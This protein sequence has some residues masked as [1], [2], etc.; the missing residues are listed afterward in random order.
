MLCKGRLISLEIELSRKGSSFLAFFEVQELHE[1][2][3]YWVMKYIPRTDNAKLLLS[4]SKMN[5]EFICDI[6]RNLKKEWRIFNVYSN[7]EVFRND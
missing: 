4:K 6:K 7:I 3:K 1:E 5:E 2:G